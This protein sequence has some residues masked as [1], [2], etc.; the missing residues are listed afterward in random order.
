[1]TDEVRD[2][3]PLDGPVLVFGGAY[4]NLEATQALFEAARAMRIPPER[5]ICT[6]DLAAYCGDPR[7][8][9]ETIRAE[10]VAVVMGNCEESLSL[11]A[12]D[13]GCGFTEGSVCA[14][15]SSNWYS[16]CA[17][18]LDADAKA[19]MGTLPR[20][21]RFVVGGAR[22]C[23]VH[24]AVSRINSYVFAS[25][26]AGEKA[27]E[28][29]AAGADGIVGGH[30]GLPF[31][32]TTAGRLWHNAGVIGMPAN[33]GTNRVWYGVLRPVGRGIEVD[34]MALE[35]DFETARRKM[36]VRGLPAG[37]ANALRTGLWPSLEIL[38]APERR[39]SGLAIEA[40]TVRWTAETVSAQSSR[41]G[42]RNPAGSRVV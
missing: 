31:T 14:A 42:R 11:G 40:S 23:A 10:D 7:E 34:L 37:Y 28:I 33:D 1:V 24:G 26:P 32:Q 21:I 22:L 5:I 3:G 8:T 35:Y 13:C 36:I 19:W 38:T 29:A 17:A 30:A 2:L 20:R 9:V 39:A 16:F 4:G 6:G 27:V 12:D 18:E 25:T 41:A 15:L